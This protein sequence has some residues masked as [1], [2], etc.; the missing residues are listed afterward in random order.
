MD[1]GSTIKPSSEAFFRTDIASF[2]LM[3]SLNTSTRSTI[4]LPHLWMKYT[5]RWYQLKIPSDNC[6]QSVHISSLVLF[7]LD[8]LSSIFLNPKAAFRRFLKRFY[9]VSIQYFWDHTSLLKSA[10]RQS[11]PFRI[12]VKFVILVSLDWTLAW[13]TF[14]ENR[15]LHDNDK[16]K[17]SKTVKLKFCLIQISLWKAN[18]NILNCGVWQTKYTRTKEFCMLVLK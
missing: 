2:T 14:C 17:S 4:T 18:T 16:Q 1:S 15:Y 13:F 10:L 8:K 6:Q 9:G 5:D 3:L 12:N 11:S 7:Q